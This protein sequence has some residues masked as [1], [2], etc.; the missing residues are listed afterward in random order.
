MATLRGQLNSLTKVE[1]NLIDDLSSREV[2]QDTK[3][4]EMIGA[5]L[6]DMEEKIKELNEGKERQNKIL[7]ARLDNKLKIL[8]EELV[9][10]HQNQAEDITDK[11]SKSPAYMYK[12]ML[13]LQKQK[14]ER[15]QLRDNLRIETDQ[16]VEELERKF[17]LLRLREIK[18]KELKF[19][20]KLIEH[21]DFDKEELADVFKAM[22][23]TRSKEEL[24]GLFQNAKVL[25][26][27]EK[28]RRGPISLLGKA[29]EELVRR[30]SS[31]RFQLSTKR[32]GLL[33]PKIRPRRS[34][35][36]A[37]MFPRSIRTVAQEA[38]ITRMNSR[39]I[40]PSAM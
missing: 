14:N 7:Q 30:Q 9:A 3:V 17:E 21:A 5:H 25:T 27:E 38:L 33:K 34:K 32:Q 12:K 2:L 13:L 11:A 1:L 20:S 4:K 40:T 24:D 10:K 36:A 6:K 35:D 15:L 31:Q 22:F 16:S 26:P 39:S 18:M 28:E 29:K 8:E 19:I 23:V 37:Q